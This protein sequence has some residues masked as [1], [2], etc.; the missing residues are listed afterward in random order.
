[1]SI[2]ILLLG[3]SALAGAAG[4]GGIAKGG[5]QVLK[6]NYK[7]IYYFEELFFP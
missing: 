4:V 2:S 6:A 3:A 7:S 5:S 1:M